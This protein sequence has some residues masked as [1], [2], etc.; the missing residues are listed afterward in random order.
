MKKYLLLLALLPLSATAQTPPQPAGGTEAKIDLPQLQKIGYLPTDKEKLRPEDKIDLKRPNPFGEKAKKVV[1]SKVDSNVESEESKIRSFFMDRR[2]TGKATSPEGRRAIA[3]DGLIL[4]EGQRIPPILPNQTQIL[5]VT[6]ITEKVL[7]ISWV[8]GGGTPGSAPR[9]IQKRLDLEPKVASMLPGATGTAAT[10]SQMY[11]TD[12]KGDMVNIVKS[13][14]SPTDII[15]SLPP[16]D[17]AGSSDPLESAAIDEQAMPETEGVPADSTAAVDVMPQLPPVETP[18]ADA[19]PAAEPANEPAAEPSAAPVDPAA[20]EDQVQP[21]PDLT[22]LE[23]TPA[24][25]P[26]ESGK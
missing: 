26:S 9:K 16:N 10:E 4:E 2:I 3:M 5:R 6:R 24:P 17:A 25:A 12:Q 22:P 19:P 8:E 20:T 15:N 23:E 1:A 11:Y 13:P 14:Q 7:E 21:D 18:G